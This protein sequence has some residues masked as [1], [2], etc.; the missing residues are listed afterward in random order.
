[1]G[2]PSLAS[3]RKKQIIKAFSQ[4]VNSIGYEATTLEKIAKR[5]GVK[6]TMI[7]H[8]FGN[9]E[10]LLASAIKYLTEEYQNDFIELAKKLPERR[11]LE[12][13]MDFLFGGGFN[14]RPK[15]DAVINALV[16][17]SYRNESA[18]IFLR[19][20]YATFEQVCLDEIKTAFPH[21]P[22]AH[23]RQVAYGLM[24]LAEQNATFLSIGMDVERSVDARHCAQLLLRTLQAGKP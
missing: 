4:C 9:R 8:Y 21:A 12:I 14:Q 18:R 22:L 20:M 2:R 24:C 6:R 19:Q 13:L 23:S 3:V 1:M 5:A 10:A 17:A 16:A 7:R 15:D 11:R